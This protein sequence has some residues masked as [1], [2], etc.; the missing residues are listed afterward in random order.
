VPLLLVGLIQRDFHRAREQHERPAPQ[1]DAI[2]RFSTL[3]SNC[4]LFLG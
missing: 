1:H 2:D 4:F 3:G